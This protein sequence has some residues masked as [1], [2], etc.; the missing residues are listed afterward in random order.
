MAETTPPPPLPVEPIAFTCPACGASTAYAPGTTTMK[1]P[2]CGAVQQIETDDHTIV[3]HSYDEWATLAPKPVATIGTVTLRCQGCGATTETDDI[4]G[5]CQFCGGVLVALQ[6]PE[7][8]IAPEAVVPFG[9]DKT[10]A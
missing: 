9:L 1:C 3:E 6:N 4:A 10:K 5:T 7:G 2:S 8:L